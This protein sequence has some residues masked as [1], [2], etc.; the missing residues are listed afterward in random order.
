VPPR[1]NAGSPFGALR[2]RSCSA[3][4]VCQSEARGPLLAALRDAEA[5]GLDVEGVFR[6]LS[7]FVR[8]TTLR[9]LLPSSTH[10]WRL[11]HTLPARSG[12]RARLYRRDHPRAVGVTDPDMVRALDE[13]AVAV[14]NRARELAVHA[15][16]RRETWVL[17]LG[18]APVDRARHERWLKAVSTVAAYRER[19][20]I[21]D[22][23]PFG[24]GG[25]V[26]TLDAH[27]HRRRAEL[28]IADALRLSNEDRE[29][30]RPHKL[31]TLPAEFVR[32]LSA[33]IEL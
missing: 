31:S 17:C 16:E 29:H 18:A 4:Q 7:L 30:R 15:I 3:Q 6:T 28:A 21:A 2:T 14:Q 11:G 10:A 22:D 23:G 32:E 24:P 19:W 9:T 26:R 20:N 33:G 5:R 12:E 25:A 1:S 13:R 8:S 27:G